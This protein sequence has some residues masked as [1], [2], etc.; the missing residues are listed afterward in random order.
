ME[1]DARHAPYP[2]PWLDTPYKILW[3]DVQQWLYVATGFE[4][5][6]W[7]EKATAGHLPWWGSPAL[8]FACMALA[9]LCCVVEWRGRR[10]VH[11][12]VAL[13]AF[14]ATPP[15]A[16]WLPSGQEERDDAR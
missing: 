7:L 5:H 12:L 9:A 14:R 1:E 16:V 3:L 15:I 11:W 6:R 10:V 2:V 13:A 4:A 8:F